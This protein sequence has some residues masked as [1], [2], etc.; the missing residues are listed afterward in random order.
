MTLDEFLSLCAAEPGTSPG[1]C[2]QRA[3]DQSVNGE[4]C[5]GNLVADEHGKRCVPRSIIDRK[6]SV[7][8]KDPL[9]RP[10]AERKATGLVLPV[11]VASGLALAIVIAFASKK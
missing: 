3:A 1:E 9:P 6:V 5:D 11:V 4:F 7:A 10:A 2:H 8:K